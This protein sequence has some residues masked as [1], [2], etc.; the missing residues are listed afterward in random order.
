ML[1]KFEIRIAIEQLLDTV[2]DL[3][4]AGDAV[5]PDVGLFLRGPASLPVRFTR[6]R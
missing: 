4:F 3:R 2:T 5:P 1:S 6:R